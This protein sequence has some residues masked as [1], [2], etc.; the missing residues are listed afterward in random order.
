LRVRVL[1][2][3]I[4]DKIYAAE[5]YIKKLPAN[6]INTFFDDII[7]NNEILDDLL[8]YKDDFLTVYQEAKSDLSFF[9]QRIK[10]LQAQKTVDTLTTEEANILRCYEGTKW[11]II[12]DFFAEGKAWETNAFNAFKNKRVAGY[13][14]YIPYDQVYLRTT[15]GT[16]IVSVGDIV[17]IKKNSAGDVIDIQLFETKLSAST[18]TTTNQ[19]AIRKAITNGEELEI[20]TSKTNLWYI[21]P[22]RAT[23]QKIKLSSWK[24]VY[25]SN[26]TRNGQL[27]IN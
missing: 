17:A 11:R 25:S 19:N 15:D 16:E 18:N 22:V 24:K 27:I 1:K 9:S 8:L 12:K 5:S 26:G 10:S 7:T 4:I 20:R 3:D 14:D 23:G 21:L 13:E 6:K 2:S